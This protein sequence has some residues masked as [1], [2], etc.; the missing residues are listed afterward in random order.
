MSDEKQVDENVKP[1]PGKK[2]MSLLGCVIWV[3]AGLT[4]LGILIALL[5]PARCVSREA[6]RRIQCRNNL[7]HIALALHNYH[8]GYGCFPPAYTVAEQG[9]RMHSW[10]AL[11]LPFV[12]GIYKEGDYDFSQPWNS[13]DN[14]AFA[15]ESSL[16][17][18]FSCPNER[19]EEPDRRT[20]SYV[21]LVGPNAFSEGLTGRKFEDIT[22]DHGKTIIVGEMSHSDIF[23]TEP[24][25]LDTELMS[26][27]LNDPDQIGL[28]SYHSSG[29]H[30]A[31]AD[32]AVSWL[33]DGMSPETLEA[34][35]T[36][37]G[38]EEIEDWKW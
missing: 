3:I 4:G 8:H 11:I 30:V 24:R 10:R 35:I 5:L 16:F 14:I 31:F 36:I 19:K 29:V 7:K 21:M 32:G 34:L 6:A 18:I 2:D 26:F 22:D 33:N 38:G 15:E 17:A 20:T 25:D 9:R 12:E 28:R 23:W 1:I 13:P 37:N 27:K